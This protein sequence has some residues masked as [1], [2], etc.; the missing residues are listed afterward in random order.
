MIETESIDVVPVTEEPRTEI[1]VII[2]AGWAVDHE[3]AV[4]A[5]TVYDV[6][7]GLMTF[8]SK[9]V[10]WHAHIVSSDVHDTRKFRIEQL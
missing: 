1:H 5:I 9:T 3:G 2:G 10:E 7:K 4:Q 8:A 6:S